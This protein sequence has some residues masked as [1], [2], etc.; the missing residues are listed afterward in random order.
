MPFSLVMVWLR[1]K[2]KVEIN[3]IEL[4][5]FSFEWLKFNSTIT[6]CTELLRLREKGIRTVPPRI[7]NFWKIFFFILNPT[8]E[9]NFY[10]VKSH[11]WAFWRQSSGRFKIWIESGKFSWFGPQI[12]PGAKMKGNLNPTHHYGSPTT[13]KHYSGRCRGSIRLSG[14]VGDVGCVVITHS[15]QI[16]LR[17]ANLDPVHLTPHLITHS[18]RHLY[19]DVS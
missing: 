15:G 19:I 6:R 10:P 9:G 17:K 5:H 16:T 13:G 18:M 4:S 7:Y 11:P 2:S 3:I 12:N 1:F 14:M 8:R